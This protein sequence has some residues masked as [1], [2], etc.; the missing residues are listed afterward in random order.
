[1]TKV[2]QIMIRNSKGQLLSI[3]QA[4]GGGCGI[5]GNTNSG[6]VEAASLNPL[7]DAPDGYLNAKDLANVLL[8][9][10]EHG[11]NPAQ[12]EYE[13]DMN[14]LYSDSHGWTDEDIDIME[15]EMFK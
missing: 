4:D 10:E 6:Q 5:M 9:F 13:E 15:R 7:A 8:H 12:T 11:T 1:M 2:H 3:V 14:R